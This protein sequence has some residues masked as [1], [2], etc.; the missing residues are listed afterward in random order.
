MS[1]FSSCGQVVAYAPAGCV[2][3]PDTLEGPHSSG[4]PILESAACK[5]RAAVAKTGLNPK[6][7][8]LGYA[9]FLPEEGFVAVASG[10]PI[11]I[12]YQDA[13]DLVQR[14]RPA[15]LLSASANA[16]ASNFVHYGPGD[17]SSPD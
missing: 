8:V 9:A 11:Y 13:R 6:F 16:E 3:Q 1:A 12:P 7:I 4:H 14:F 5:I 15:N 10:A 2:P 17:D